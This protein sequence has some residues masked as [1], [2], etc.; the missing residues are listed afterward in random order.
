MD[1]IIK[2]MVYYLL[3]NKILVLSV[4]FIITVYSTLQVFK[5]E[6]SNNIDYWLNVENRSYKNYN[7]FTSLFG[8]D[9]FFVIVYKSDSL[10]SNK[11]LR[12]NINLT[13]KFEALEGVDQVLSLANLKKP[14][15]SPLGLFFFPLV[16]DNVTNT[17][18]LKEKILDHKI[19]IDNLISRDARS[20]VFY[21][22]QND[23][24][25]IF[26]LSKQIKEAIR[27]S[28]NS[29]NFYIP[30]GI[31]IAVEA[32]NLAKGE[33][34]KFIFIAIILI[35]LLLYVVFR[36]FALAVSSIISGIIA[37]IWTLALFKLGGGQL[38][39]L[40]GI[41]PLIVLV[42]S[43]TF[44]IH[45]ITKI[46]SNVNPDVSIEKTITESVKSVFYP[47]VL[48]AITT[49]LAILTFGLSHIGPIKLFG[50]YTSLGIVLAFI[51]NVILIPIMSVTLIKKNGLNKSNVKIN[52]SITNSYL[53]IISGKG[54]K[55]V[56]YLSI[57]FFILSIAAISKLHTETDVYRFFKK[58]ND[59]SIAK[60]EMERSFEG[61]FPIEIVF[62]LYDN[63][64]DSINSFIDKLGVIENE[65]LKIEKI[66]TCNSLNSALSSF[67]L[68]DE[69]YKQPR[70][71]RVQS[72]TLLRSYYISENN[73]FRLTAKA[74]WLNNNETED[75]VTKIENKLDSILV[76]GNVSYYLSG[77]ALIF[78]ELNDEILINQ[79]QSI[80]LSYL[81]IMIV[82]GFLFR[83]L[84]LFVLGVLPNVIPVINVLALMALMDIYIDIGTVLIA[85]I[86]IGVIVDDTI[87]F[88]FF[89]RKEIK[90]SNKKAAIYNTFV[91]VLKP[92]LITTFVISIGFSIMIF[93]NYLPISYLGFFISLNL[94]LALF[95]DLV[96]LPS[97]IL[98]IK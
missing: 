69:V 33:S 80:L 9:Q 60:A 76:N 68:K 71:L 24:C 81:I 88:L 67:N 72:N 54:G 55:F 31:S 46:I 22:I 79:I 91:S 58:T 86:S 26:N 5:L 37:M 64:I 82:F 83:N 85:S 78:S 47:G 95:Y 1:T 29:D 25:D 18:K 92:L 40:S 65:L 51:I 49:S 14:V 93:S 63:N 44:S 17:N 15:K 36:N 75:V 66:K 53:N 56:I 57:I 62:K 41:M 7:H 21:V 35:I 4:V 70:I 90:R 23:T 6:S 13:R 38:D 30:T 19:L 39:M 96:L 32:T 94:L 27:N 16:T 74:K 84:K 12:N 77:A 48:S 20:T 45:L 59:I 87:Y 52:G 3:K 43:I 11:E 89:F 97:I 61:V 28:P 34:S 98:R 2:A 50:I 42:M 8:K 10:F 73:I